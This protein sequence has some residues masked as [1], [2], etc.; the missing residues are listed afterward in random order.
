L[1]DCFISQGLKKLA[2]TCSSVGADILRLWRSNNLHGWRHNPFCV[3]DS[4]I[5]WPVHSTA[6]QPTGF[7]SKMTSSIG[8]L[9]STR[10]GIR[11]TSSPSWT[12]S[13]APTP[14]ARSLKLIQLL[15]GP[16]PPT[17][18]ADT[19]DWNR[20]IKR[21]RML[22]SIMITHITDDNLKHMIQAAHSLDGYEAWLLLRRP[23][24]TPTRSPMT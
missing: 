10:T 18:A 17:S 2:K 9:A 13:K 4:R 24:A 21:N 15:H 11:A 14:T 23:T 1:R 6:L 5:F 22:A 19:E 3:R 20:H 7:A 12:L 8:W 16:V